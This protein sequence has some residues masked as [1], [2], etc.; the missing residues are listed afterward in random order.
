MHISFGVLW[1]EKKEIDFVCGQKKIKKIWQMVNN[2]S[3][4][5]PKDLQLAPMFSLGSHD[6]KNVYIVVHL[7]RFYNSLG[8]KTDDASE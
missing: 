7:T 3:H 4:D 2:F 6:S 5:A 1:P 8:Q